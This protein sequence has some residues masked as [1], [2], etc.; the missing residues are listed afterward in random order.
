[1]S[2]NDLPAL[3]MEREWRAIQEALAELVADGKFVLERLPKPS[4]EALQERLLGEPVH[5]LHFVGHGVFDES[6]QSGRLAL[7]GVDGRS[8]LVQG[9]QLASLLRNHSA[10]RLVYLNA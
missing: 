1:A 8:R 6:G 9:E 10:M 7:E 4:L 2:P 5:I 3:D